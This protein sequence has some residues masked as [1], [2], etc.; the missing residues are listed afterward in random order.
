MEGSHD[1]HVTPCVGH[2]TQLTGR[3][4]DQVLQVLALH[5]LLH[6]QGQGAQPLAAVGAVHLDTHIPVTAGPHPVQDTAEEGIPG[7]RGREGGGR[8]ERFT[9]GPHP[10]L[11]TPHSSFLTPHPSLHTTH[12]TALTPHPS[13]LTDLLQ[14]I[15]EA[16]HW[17]TRWRTSAGR[18]GSG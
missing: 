6:G 14:R 1:C 10:S 15:S 3:G 9:P 16:L 2:M 13:P 4:V 12:S 17:Y 11:C 7:G 5:L 18:P 8:R